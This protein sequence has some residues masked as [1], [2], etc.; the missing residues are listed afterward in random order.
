M[1]HD[2]LE[3][4]GR[5]AEMRDKQARC[6]VAKGVEAH[7]FVRVTGLSRLWRKCFAKASVFPLRL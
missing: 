5:P 3:L 4:F 7:V 2:D 6:R 1:T